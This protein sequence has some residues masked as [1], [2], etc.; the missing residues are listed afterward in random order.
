MSFTCLHRLSQNMDAPTLLVSNDGVVRGI[1]P[2]QS[3][4]SASELHT[5]QLVFRRLPHLSRRRQNTAIPP[6]RN[7]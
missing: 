3:V 7:V 5:L 2:Q 4:S 1:E 6:E